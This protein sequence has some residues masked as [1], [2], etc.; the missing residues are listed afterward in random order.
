M[1]VTLVKSYH[2]SKKQTLEAD[3]EYEV[4]DALH[5]ILEDGGYIKK[6]SKKEV[7]EK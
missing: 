3:K 6:P 2:L 1:K 4:S 7:K 5:S